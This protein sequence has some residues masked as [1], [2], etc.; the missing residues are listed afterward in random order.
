M[1]LDKC[2]VYVVVGRGSR[3]PCIQASTGSGTSPGC[4][5]RKQTDD[6]AAENT[7][8]YL[9]KMMQTCITFV[10]ESMVLIHEKGLND[11]DL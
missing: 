9:Q 7:H 4:W 11:H 8:Q 5:S 2:V 6:R 3:R 1:F 10:I